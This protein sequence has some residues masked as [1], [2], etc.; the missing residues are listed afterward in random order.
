MVVINMMRKSLICILLGTF[1]FACSGKNNPAFNG[2]AAK[3]SAKYLMVE[4]DVVTVKKAIAEKKGKIV[5]LNMWATWC[6]P[7]VEEFPYIITLY[8]KYKDKGLD[9]ITISF[10]FEAPVAISFLE[11]QKADFTNFLK[12]P[13]QD[14]NDFING[15]DEEWMGAIPAT[16][17]YDRNGGSQFFE[18]GR[19]NPEELENKIIELLQK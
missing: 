14:E 11:K 10:D 17:L 13:Q 18:M 12:N 6:R 19:F 16:W 2:N 7:C 3:G 5:L 8:N 15:I 9:V 4:A 1:L